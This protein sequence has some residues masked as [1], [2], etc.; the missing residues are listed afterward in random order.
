MKHVTNSDE[1]NHDAEGLLYD[2]QVRTSAAY[3][4][5]GGSTSRL[6]AAA[7]ARAA[8]KT[9]ERLRTLGSEGRGLSTGAVDV[10]IRLRTLGADGAHL[11][12]LARSAGMTPRNATGLVDTLEREGLVRRDP[13]PADRRSVLAR[14]TPAGLAWLDDFRIPTQRAMAALFDGFSE[15]EL[16]QLRHLCLR[17]VRNQRRI[18]AHLTP[19]ERDALD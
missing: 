3:F 8:N 5:S 11:G 19:A 6:E 2:P 10:L 13:D 1:L 7:A 15:P 12:E 14:I 18:T 9:L 4:A 16:H 17:L